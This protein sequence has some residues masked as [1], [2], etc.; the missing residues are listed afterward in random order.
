MRRAASGYHSRSSSNLSDGRPATHGGRGRGL[1]GG[2]RGPALLVGVAARQQIMLGRHRR[3]TLADLADRSPAAAAG[4][5]FTSLGVRGG[6]PA[7][8]QF[9]TLG[10][11]GQVSG[12]L[13]AGL[14]GVVGVRS[15]SDAGLHDHPRRGDQRAADHQQGSRRYRPR[16]SRHRNALTRDRYGPAAGRDDAVCFLGVRGGIAGGTLVRT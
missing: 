13:S 7:T 9:R 6:R 16:V 2:Q 3:L 1:P 11:F 12:V 4:V 14:F 5:G 15:G 10:Q 8:E